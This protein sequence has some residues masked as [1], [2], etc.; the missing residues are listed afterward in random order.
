LLTAFL[1]KRRQIMAL[2]LVQHGKSLAKDVDPDQGLSEEGITEVKHIAGVAKNYNVSVSRIQ[3]S[4]KTRARQTAN[5]FASSL[6]PGTSVEERSGI[7]PLDDAKAVAHTLD[8]K[9]NLMLV[10]HLP[11]ME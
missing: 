1:K 6:A 2:Y 5:I 7:N 3:H 4:G 11:F 9:D 10:G 8:A